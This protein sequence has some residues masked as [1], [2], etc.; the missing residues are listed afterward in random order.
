[1]LIIATVIVSIRSIVGSFWFLNSLAFS[2]TILSLLL[3]LFCV[4]HV[5]IYVEEYIKPYDLL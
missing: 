5:C 3:N 4:L 2:F 1:M